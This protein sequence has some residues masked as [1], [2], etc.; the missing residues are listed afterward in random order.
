MRATR[1]GQRTC[2]PRPPAICS[3]AID[4]GIGGAAAILLCTAAL[5]AGILLLGGCNRGGESSPDRAQADAPAAAAAAADSA[6]ATAA[7]AQGGST[8]ADSAGVSD[9]HLAAAETEQEDRGFFARLFHRGEEEEQ[10]EEAVPVELA[11]VVVADLPNYLLSTATLEPE[12]QAE[13]LA[14]VPGEIE[15]I[16][17]EEGERVPAGAVLAIL[18]G[19]VPRV[20]LEEAEARLDALRLDLERVAALHEQNL[21]SD[22]DLQDARSAFAQGEAQRKAAALEV[23]Y[24]RITAPFTGQIAERRVDPGQ[25]VAVGTAL[26]SIVDAEPLLARIHLPEREAV[27]IT[28]GQPVVI[29]PD[30][31]PDRA[32]RGEV[33]RVAPIVDARTGTVKVTC[34]VRETA[35]LLRPGSFVR[36]KVETDVQED[37]VCIPKRA[38]VPEGEDN[39]VFKAAADSVVKTSIVTGHHNHTLVEVLEGLS[40]GE[41]VV[42]VGH[43]ALKHGS[44]IRPITPEPLGDVAKADSG[45]AEAAAR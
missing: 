2:R 9:E 18:D 6:Q 40:P 31:A 19:A 24:T 23:E 15:R 45:A 7:G 17:T 30:T 39:Y 37:V 8:A 27:R 3:T 11:E 10:E 35:D 34:S 21:A 14:K 22:K 12:K 44:K 36:V 33:L 20:A 25:T 43:G 28:P 4:W 1:S 38:L 26:F 16:Q 42:T 5:L 32:L 29:T 13:I 41:Q